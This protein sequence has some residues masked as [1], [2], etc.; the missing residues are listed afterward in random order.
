MI[1]STSLVYK[2]LEFVAINAKT[3]V[4]SGLPGVGKSLY[5]NQFKDIAIHQ[6]KEVL[7]IQWDVARKAFET[8]EI[9]E[10]FPTGEDEVHL[11]LIHI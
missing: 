11:S 3:V 2:E 6:G 10:R 7:V 8:P 1:P 5:I 4:I 9:A